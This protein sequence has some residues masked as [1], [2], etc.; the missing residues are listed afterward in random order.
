[1]TTTLPLDSH[2]V[3]LAWVRHRWH[4]LDRSEAALAMLLAGVSWAEALVLLA[5]CTL[6]S[7][8]RAQV[9]AP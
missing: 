5:G 1:M 7:T 6:P 4:E 2:A 8:A 3:D 9:G